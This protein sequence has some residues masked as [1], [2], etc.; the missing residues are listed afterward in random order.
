MARKLVSYANYNIHNSSWYKVFSQN[1]RSG[2]LTI[3][4]CQSWKVL[5]VCCRSGSQLWIL[6]KQ[7]LQIAP[8]KHFAPLTISQTLIILFSTLGFVEI[9]TTH[10]CYT[11]CKIK[12]KSLWT[13][14]YCDKK[15]FWT[16]FYNRFK[17]LKLWLL[18]TT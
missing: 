9:I 7:A 1:S 6:Y 5:Q 13:K 11:T 17:F 4:F 18:E 8:L 2:P 12:N 3:L 14:K 10:H 15:A 16:F